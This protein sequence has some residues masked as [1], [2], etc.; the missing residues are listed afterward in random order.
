[1]NR[2]DFRSTVVSTLA[3]HAW[4]TTRGITTVDWDGTQADVVSA[5]TEL[6]AAKKG[7]VLLVSQIVNEKPDIATSRQESLWCEAQLVV[8]VRTNPGNSQSVSHDD[9]VDEVKKALAGAPSAN[10]AKPIHYREGRLVRD[11]PGLI[12]TELWFEA[13]ISGGA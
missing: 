5:E 7:T 11:T 8:M 6:R 3:A 13:R 9:A 2:K 12:V 4:F 1:M 10:G